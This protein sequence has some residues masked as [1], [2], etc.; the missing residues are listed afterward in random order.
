[1]ETLLKFAVLDKTAQYNDNG[2]RVISNPSLNS[3][4]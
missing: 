4:L 3:Q 1:M 2:K